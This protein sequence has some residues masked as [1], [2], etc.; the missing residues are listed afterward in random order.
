MVRVAMKFTFHALVA[1]ALLTLV[2]VMGAPNLEIAQQYS[3]N[4]RR[5]C[6]SVSAFVMYDV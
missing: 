6:K 5:E 2:V 3:V 1:V 4:V